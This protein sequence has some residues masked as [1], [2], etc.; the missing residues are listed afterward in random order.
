MSDSKKR[1]Y[2]VGY[3]K[4]PEHTRFPKG[5]SGNPLGRPKKQRVEMGMTD[6][7]CVFNEVFEVD[8]PDGG[9]RKVTGFEAMLL[10]LI[11]KGLAGSTAAIKKIFEI[12]R[13][14]MRAVIASEPEPIE[15]TVKPFIGALVPEQLPMELWVKIYSR[16]MNLSQ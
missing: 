2:T 11:K 6:V 10:G 9:K 1:K 5:T 14:L 12:K 3:G 15:A 8:T 13:A 16:P 7:E 4:P